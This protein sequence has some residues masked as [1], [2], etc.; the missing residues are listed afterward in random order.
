MQVTIGGVVVEITK[1]IAD[2]TLGDWRELEGLGVA[3]SRGND[4]EGMSASQMSAMFWKIIQKNYV[5]ATREQTDDVPLP[6]VNEVLKAAS[7]TSGS[8][9]RPT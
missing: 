6:V 3:I 2:F 7:K 4:D 5:S 9:D 1:G 8:L